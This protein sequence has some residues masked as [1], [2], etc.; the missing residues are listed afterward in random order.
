M[1]ANINWKDP[2]GGKH[3][4]RHAKKLSDTISSIVEEAAPAVICMCEVGLPQSP[5]VRAL[6]E[7]AQRRRTGVEGMLPCC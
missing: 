7:I 5:T 4:A 6:R 3:F 1:F 2:M